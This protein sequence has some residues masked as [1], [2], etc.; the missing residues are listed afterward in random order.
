MS[1]KDVK[2]NFLVETATQLFL[3]RGIESVTIKDIA[4]E[5]G[6]GEMTIYRYFGKKQNIVAASVMLLQQ[7]VLV[8]YFKLDK[9]NTGFDKLAIFYNSYLGVFKDKPEFFRFI[10]EFDLIMR[11]EDSNSLQAYE[12]GLSVFKKQ[13]E[14]AYELG[15]KDGSVRKVDD[16]DLFYFTSTHALIELCKKLSYEQVVLT[17]DEKINKVDEIN[18]LINTF[19]M[20]FKNS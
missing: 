13:Y 9:G 5:A 20:M 8:N 11:E 6:V 17:Q 16:L 1:L 3:S 14:E 7:S 4:D 10:R 2:R 12:D 19:L 15:L 18:C